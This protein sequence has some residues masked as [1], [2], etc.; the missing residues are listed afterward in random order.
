MGWQIFVLSRKAALQDFRGSVF[1]LLGIE[2]LGNSPWTCRE[3]KELTPENYKQAKAS[4]VMSGDEEWH[5]ASSKT[6]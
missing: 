6:C 4:C 1:L 5:D 3:R 2:D